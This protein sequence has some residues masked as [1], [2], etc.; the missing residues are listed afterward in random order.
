V[1]N[2]AENLST[3]LDAFSTPHAVAVNDVSSSRV[4]E[5]GSANAG[6][7]EASLWFSTEVHPHEPQLRS[8]LRGRFP[9]VRDVDD[10]VQESYLRIWRARAAHPIQSAKTFLFTI[11]RHLAI[12]LVQRKDMTTH[13]AMGELALSTVIDGGPNAF[14]ALSYQEKISLLAH[15]LARLPDRCRQVVMLRKIHELSQKEVAAQLGISERTVEKQLARGMAHCQ[16]HLR[17]WGIQNLFTS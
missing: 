15:V 2:P 13:V 3:E 4:R 8:Y 10:V 11:A 5:C 12:N 17:E 1:T 6:A 7:D 9:G 14:D 16:R